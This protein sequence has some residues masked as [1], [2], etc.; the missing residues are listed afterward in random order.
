MKRLVTAAFF[1]FLFLVPIIVISLGKVTDMFI[2]STYA[3]AQKIVTSGFYQLEPYQSGAQVGNWDWQGHVN[4]LSYYPNAAIIYAILGLVTGVPIHVLVFMPLGILL[5]LLVFFAFAREILHSKL[6]IITYILTIV[7]YFCIAYTLSYHTLGFLFHTLTLLVLFKKLDGKLTG[8]R[9]SLLLFLLVGSTIFTYYTAS[10]WNLVFLVTIMVVPFFLRIRNVNIRSIG[11]KSEGVLGLTL[12][13]SVLYLII[14]REFYRYISDYTI[15]QTLTDF[16]TYIGSRLSGSPYPGSKEI[17]SVLSY[18]PLGRT[19]S[20]FPTGMILFSISYVFIS[21]LVTMK[22]KH[23]TLPYPF[24]F[25]FGIVVVGLW[26]NIS[27]FPLTQTLGNRYF[28]LYALLIGFYA[29]ST[30]LGKKK[31]NMSKKL[32]YVATVILTI[33]ILSSAFY[34]S[35]YKVFRGS[36]AIR[37]E[38]PTFCENSS[39]WLASHIVNDNIVSEHQIS[40]FLFMDIVRA[41]KSDSVRVFPFNEDIYVWYVAVTQRDEQT[42]SYLFT[43]RTYDKF[44]FLE[45]F[46]Q[47]PMFGDRWGYAVPPLNEKE[48]N[49]YNFTIFNKIYDDGNAIILDYNR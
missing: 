48:S 43:K 28:Q 35:Y 47:K 46:I 20:Y 5:M 2:A 30:F 25:F 6:F 23:K 32:L 18:D 14:D 7:F 13:A 34:N 21:L 31:Q 17:Y 37:S 3:L 9:S 39:N 22:S 29:I 49:L 8:S 15:T 10:A 26:E 40:G 27:Y 11:Q 44:V 42:L 19:L 16:V 33:L 38:V 1:F 36:T 41:N 4:G 45:I 24:L 12:F